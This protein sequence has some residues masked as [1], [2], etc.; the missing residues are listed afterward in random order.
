MPLI[1]PEIDK[2]KKSSLVYKFECPCNATYIG[3]TARE[4]DVRIREHNQKSRNTEIF[5][6]TSTCEIYQNSLPTTTTK[7]RSTYHFHFRNFFS[8]LKSNLFNYYDRTCA[9]AIFITLEE[10]SLNKQKDFRQLQVF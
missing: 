3:E 8:I 9:E 2:F 6:H 5:Q 7:M 1:K 4:L 10:P